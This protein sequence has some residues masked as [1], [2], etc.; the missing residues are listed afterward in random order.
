[1]NRHLMFSFTAASYV[2]R[3]D[4]SAFSAGVGVEDLPRLPADSRRNRAFKLNGV[5]GGQKIFQLYLQ[6]QNSFISSS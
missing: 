1:M 2:S 5:I 4:S 6:L 3:I